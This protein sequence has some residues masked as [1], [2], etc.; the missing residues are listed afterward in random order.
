MDA[1][2]AAGRQRFNSCIVEVVGAGGVEM[3]HLP[4]QHFPIL[5]DTT[6]ITDEHSVIAQVL[7]DKVLIKSGVYDD[8]T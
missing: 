8:R 3:P 4:P 2:D 5:P 6:D 7:C 1:Y